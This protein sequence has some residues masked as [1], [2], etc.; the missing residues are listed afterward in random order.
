V[1]LLQKVIGFLKNA[2]KQ[3]TT[4]DEPKI[5]CLVDIEPTGPPMTI[6]IPPELP[7]PGNEPEAETVR[8][9]PKPPD[10]VPPAKSREAFLSQFEVKEHPLGVVLE[11]KAGEDLPHFIARYD[12]LV[13]AGATLIIGAADARSI[14][15][16]RKKYPSIDTV[17]P[18]GRLARLH[19]RKEEV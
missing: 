12:A 6:R 1:G 17:P 3:L 18:E 16:F 7:H 14:E 13:R 15:Q 9:K 19:K 4:S 10:Y 8:Q 2:K 5:E 11:R